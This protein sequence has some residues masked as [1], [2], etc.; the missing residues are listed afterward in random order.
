[1]KLLVPWIAASL[2]AAALWASP[3]WATAASLLALG[4]IAEGTRRVI[5][6]SVIHRQV[7]VESRVVERASARVHRIRAANGP[8]PHARV[9]RGDSADA[10]TDRRWRSIE[11]TIHI[12]DAPAAEGPVPLPLWT[13][14]RV[15]LT[16][17]GARSG[18][19][20]SDDR[21]G[22]TW[23]LVARVDVLQGGDWEPID[24]DKVLGSQRLRL[25]VGVPPHHDAFKLRYGHTVFE[26]GGQDPG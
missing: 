16:G 13:P 18:A 12:P 10:D 3:S 8:K 20:S 11:V 25:L 15:Q 19:P 17:P 24:S 22:T 5:R 6:A 26:N 1:M 7:A 21:F 9:A 23:G 14:G 4:L 2:A